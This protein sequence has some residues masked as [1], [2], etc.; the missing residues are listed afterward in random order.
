MLS[1]AKA[2]E[3][4]A[5]WVRVVTDGRLQIIEERTITKPYGWVF[6]YN[7]PD[8]KVVIAGN[9]PIIV[10]RV[11]GE[12]RITGTGR[13]LKSYLDD[14]EAT[15]PPARLQMGL[16]SEPSSQTPPRSSA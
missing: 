12:V 11:N 13:A 16:P 14:Y 2:L 5:N 4:A 15:L 1:Y 10:D 7:S 8:P 9:A 3:L 6:F